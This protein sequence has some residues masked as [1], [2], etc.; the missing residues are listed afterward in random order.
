[1]E[2]LSSEKILVIQT[3]FIGDAVLT[4]PMVQKLTELFPAAI[5]DVVCI[6][7]TAELFKSSPYVN[8]VF[9]YDKH[10]KQKS[11]YKL[12]TF[13]KLLR[14]TKFN[15]IYSPHRSFRSSLIVMLSGVR[16]TYGFTNSSFKYVYKNLI[17][18]R[19]D[20]HEVQRNLDLI[21]FKYSE[22]DWKILPEV[23]SDEM[24]RETVQSFLVTFNDQMITAV[25]PGAVWNTKIFP[26]DYYC[27]LIKFLRD[28]LY[29]VILIGSKSNEKLC[30]EIES[31]FDSGVISTAGKFSV[32]GT[33][34]LLRNCKLLITNDSA[35]THFAMAANIPVLTIYCST[36]PAFG[37]FPYNNE[38]CSISYD[39]LDCKPCGIHGHNSC[40]VKT[41]DCA[42]KIDIEQIKKIIIEILDG[43][44]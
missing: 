32:P 44:K 37:F 36:I 38:S 10:V 40:P 22:Q 13:A 23:K 20:K 43:K 25:A 8:N 17:E 12:W 24:V 31:K 33:I 35:P 30:R 1:M 2:V 29:T 11:L 39:E 7:A 18:Y 41:F 14:K 15:R 5:I 4:L 6:P 21:E 27:E 26:S 19:P 9:I 28:E 16:E 42:H 3:A 34:E